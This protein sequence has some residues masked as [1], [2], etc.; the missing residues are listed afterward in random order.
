MGGY[1]SILVGSYKKNIY[2]VLIDKD[3]HKF[4]SKKIISEAEK[5]S[6]LIDYKKLSYIYMDGIK[7]YIKIGNESVLL[8][9]TDGAC[10]LS[11]D[12]VNKNIYTSFYGAGIL[13]VLSLKENKWQLSQEIKY[14]EHSHI[15]FALY[16]DNIDLVGVCDLGDNKFYLYENKDQNLI[17]KTHYQ[18]KDKE[19]PR[20]F[21]H[22]KTKPIIYVLNEHKPSITV[23]K[24]EDGK[25]T[26]LEQV[27]LIDGA[28]SAIRISHDNKYLYAGVR[29]SNYIF[30][31]EILENG[32]LKLIQKVSTKGD[33]PRD[34]NLVLD[35]QYLVVANM[36]SDNLALFR[37]NNGKLYLEDKDFELNHGASIMTKHN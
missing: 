8:N 21:I 27:K 1:M 12:D 31:F 23:L 25:L 36:H 19:G 9:E 5:P 26:L 29:I 37:L 22:H 18:F 10:H 3:N 17:E 30:A 24:Y 13:K 34:F 15:H 35:E 2:E 4:L 20:H 11:Y 33:H 16:I 7:Q 28:G 6:F 32:Q 14:Q